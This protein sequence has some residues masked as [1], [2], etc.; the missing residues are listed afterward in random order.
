MSSTT[1]SI[2]GNAQQ[3][4][5]LQYNTKDLLTHRYLGG[6][7]SNALQE[8]NYT[9]NARNFLTSINNP[10]SLG[11]DLFGMRLRYN[12]VD[13]DF[14]EAT[15][16]ENG[17][18]AQTSW[19]TPT[20]AE[21]ATYGYSYDY[22]NRLTKAEYGT[23][24]NSG[25]GGSLVA[26]NLNNHYS[27]D[28]VYEDKRGNIKN[29]VRQGRININGTWTSQEID[30]LTLH[31]K[32]NSNQLSYIEDAAA[33][34]SC[35]SVRN[36]TGLEG[37]SKV[38]Y[39]TVISSNQSVEQG[40]ILDYIASDCIN[41]NEEFEVELGAE[42]LADIGPCRPEGF[43]FVDDVDSGT[44]LYDAN[45]NMIYDP[46]KNITISYSYLNLPYRIDF[47]SGEWIEFVYDASGIKLRKERSDEYKKDYVGGIEY[48]DDILEAIYHAEGRVVLK[49]DV[50]EYQYRIA[51]Q[52][53]NTR[54]L[55]RNDGNGIAELLSEHHFY[56]FG[57][58]LHGEWNS[59]ITPAQNYLYNATEHNDDF[60][61]NLNMTFFRAYNPLIC[62]WLQTDPL[63]NMITNHSTY[64]YAY[65]NPIAFLDPTGLMGKTTNEI[66][67]EAWN[68]TPEGTNA[69]YSIIHNKHG[70]EEI[71]REN[72][73]NGV[74]ITYS[75]SYSLQ[76][77]SIN[78]E[79]LW[80]NY[81]SYNI[82]HNDPKTGKDCFSNHCAINVSEALHKSG[83]KAGGTKCWNCSNGGIHSIRAQ[84][85]AKWLNITKIKGISSVK[86]LT[87]NNYENYVQGKQGIIFFKDYWQRSGETGDTR[88]GDHS[89]LW[90]KNTLAKI[91][92]AQT[93]IRRA[94]PEFAKWSWLDLSD[95]RKSK[96]V[97]FWE[98]KK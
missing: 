47:D 77:R 58:S 8:V 3:I 38:E 68:A 32:N 36:L 24:D 26:V 22:L 61:L 21:E 11:A 29:I 16:Q 7:A 79:E 18:I 65:N 5:E 63:A 92:W 74:D 76:E 39:G 33:A 35:P 10:S 62:R 89:D 41:L 30:N 87:G 86:K 40:A 78:F 96:E 54:A 72:N 57:Q 31:Y 64:S 9:Y 27:S 67:E 37:G 49:D 42:F 28:Y 90:N 12:V 82:E 70:G 83:V 73:E 71:S 56:A 34:P 75:G 69:S 93:W 50:F 44:Y 55:F 2:D 19:A 91:G 53:S 95:L 46:D 80:N 66:I 85:L 84:D 59:K 48:T 14:T 43:G 23:V 97:L 17:N 25:T 4:N 45:G 1:H 98:V 88:T 52:L 13:S 81:P 51:D 15:A 94:F 60:E 6:N 20:M